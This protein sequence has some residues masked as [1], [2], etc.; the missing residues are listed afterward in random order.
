MNLEEAKEIVRLAEEKKAKEKIKAQK[1]REKW[2]MY[3]SPQ[4]CKGYSEY[5]GGEHSGGYYSKSRCSCSRIFT[6]RYL[7]IQ[8]KKEEMSPKEYMW[9]MSKFYDNNTH[10]DSVNNATDRSW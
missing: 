2:A 7:K 5:R 1:K 3:K 4:C 8:S 9:K 6:D 10:C